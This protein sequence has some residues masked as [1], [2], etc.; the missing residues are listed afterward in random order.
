M[1]AELDQIYDGAAS[2][3]VENAHVQNWT[4]ASYIRGSY[5]MEIDADQAINEILVP[6]DGRVHFA[7]EA[8]GKDAQATVQG[9]F[10]SAIDAVKC[11]L[12]G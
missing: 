11:I 3:L 2:R 10:F 4:R 9:A 8:L 7:G 5:S 1:L 6:I 12:T